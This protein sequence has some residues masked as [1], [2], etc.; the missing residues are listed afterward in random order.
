MLYYW[1]LGQDLS[2]VHL[3]H[4][5]RKSA[6]D[7]T[8]SQMRADLVYLS[9]P[10]ANSR[11]VKQHRTMFPE[12]AGFDVVDEAYSR[13]IHV[14]FPLSINNGL[15]GNVSRIRRAR[16]RSFHWHRINFGNSGA[17]LRRSEDIRQ[18]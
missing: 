14:V 2:I 1:K 11:D 12:R 8:I 5:L 15:F 17:V 18:E 3:D 7:N 6:S 16:K 4:S 10:R 13:E 9:P